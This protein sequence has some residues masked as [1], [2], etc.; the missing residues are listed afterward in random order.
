[1]YPKD[2]KVTTI[3]T[4]SAGY[5]CAKGLPAGE[6]YLKEEDPPAGFEKNEAVTNVTLD[7]DSKVTVYDAPYTGK[8]RLHKTYDSDLKNEEK[9]VFEIYNSKEELVDTI[10]TGEDGI[11][12]TKNCHMGHIRFI[13]LKEH[14]DLKRS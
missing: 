5:G 3:V 8:I 11:A 10:T 7:K 14:L 12:E 1:M 6:Y 9:A 2:T 13:R 4:D